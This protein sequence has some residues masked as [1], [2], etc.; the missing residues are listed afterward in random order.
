MSLSVRDRFVI[1]HRDNPRIFELF[2]KFAYEAL[3][4]GRPRF[5]SWAIINRIRWEVDIE[6]NSGDGFKISNDFI[7]YYSRLLIH[8]H[9]EFKGFITVRPMNGEAWVGDEFH[10]RKL[11]EFDDKA[12]GQLGMGL[13][14]PAKQV[15]PDERGWH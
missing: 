10:D 9:P 14:V 7:A 11:S 15:H 5:S 4:S 13:D 2:K 1:Y 12:T 3:N 6:T 8:R